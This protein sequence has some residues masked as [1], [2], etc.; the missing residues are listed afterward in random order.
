MASCLGVFMDKYAPKFIKG[1]VS[2]FQETRSKIIFNIV[3]YNRCKCVS[4]S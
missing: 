4:Q 2:E 3:M 1:N